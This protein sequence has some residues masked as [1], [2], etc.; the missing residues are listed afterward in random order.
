MKRLCHIVLLLSILCLIPNSTGNTK[1][2]PIPVPLAVLFALP[3]GQDQSPSDPDVVVAVAEQLKSSRLVDI[4]SFNPDL[5]AV[6]RAILERRLDAEALNQISDPKK[7]ILIASSLGGKYAVQVLGTVRENKVTISIQITNTSGESWA[8]VADSEIATTEGRPDVNRMN[9]IRTAASSAVSQVLIGAFGQ[10]AVL[11]SPKAVSKETESAATAREDL[12]ATAS[13]K[14]SPSVGRDKMPDGPRNIEAEYAQ[15]E[16]LITQYVS[17]KDYPNVIT[18]LKRAVDLKPSD[19]SLRIRLAEIYLNIGMSELAIDECKRALLIDKQNL[20]ARA[21]LAKLY[22]TRDSLEEAVAL[23]KEVAQLNLEDSAVRIKLGDLYWNLGKIEEATSAY[24]EAATLKPSDPGPHERLQRLYAARKMYPEMLEHQLQAILLSNVTAISSNGRYIALARIIQDECT[25]ILG[26][27]EKAPKD[28]NSSRITREDFYKECK[29]TL[30]RSDA[31]AAF[32]STQSVQSNGSEAH[33]HGML[34][35]SLLAQAA[36][37]MVSYLETEKEHYFTQA[38][39]LIS[40]AKNEL[41]LFSKNFP[42]E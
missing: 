14:V 16:K 41:S 40:E 5:P 35:V 36:G 29:D 10:D 1:P 34:A 28:F 19:I 39:L 15:L 27:L 26:R 22:E 11:E 30:A 20:P 18:S 6:A 13:V 25:T 23:Y 4:L 12:Q 31:V 9:A 2:S 3:A 8:S 37:C 33:S 24:Q 32:F 21:M 17:A 7:A 38:T 42:K